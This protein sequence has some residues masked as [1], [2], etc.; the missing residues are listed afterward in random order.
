MPQHGLA[1]YD[2]AWPFSF[3]NVCVLVDINAVRAVAGSW[4]DLG[5]PDQV[6]LCPFRSPAA[7]ERPMRKLANAEQATSMNFASW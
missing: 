1:S 2:E 7:S 5:D 6:G 3:V 4:P